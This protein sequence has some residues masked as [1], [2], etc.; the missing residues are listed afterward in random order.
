MDITQQI[1]S[2]I[3]VYNKYAKYLPEVERRET[4]NEIVTRNKDM[5]IQKF[6]HLKDEIESIYKLVYDKKI[7]PSMR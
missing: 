7:L 3:T 2:E 4:W 6:P 1:L 5:H